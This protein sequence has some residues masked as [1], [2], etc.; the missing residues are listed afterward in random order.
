MIPFC[1]LLLFQDVIMVIAT[2]GLV[3]VTE[4]ITAGTHVATCGVCC[5][6]YITG[7]CF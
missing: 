5:C 4:I 2:K 7:Y 6:S 1:V 3:K